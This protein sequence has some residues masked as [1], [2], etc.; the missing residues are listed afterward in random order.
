MLS[1]LVALVLVIACAN[2]ANLLLS[3]AVSR[4]REVAVRLSLGASR[5][6]LV[7]QLLTESFMLAAVAGITG[8]V[9]GLL[10]DGRDHGVRA[11]GGHADRSRDCGWI[12]RRCS[13]R[14]ACRS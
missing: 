10:D 14:S 2:V 5:T 7:R 3:K 11:A 8:V 9:D 12:R 6:R 1:V 13:S 4:R